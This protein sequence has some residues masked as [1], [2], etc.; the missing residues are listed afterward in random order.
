M[1]AFQYEA[2][3]LS[4]RTRVN[5]VINADTE[6]EAREMLREQ[7][8]VPTKLVVIKGGA[9]IADGKVGPLDFIFGFFKGI[10]DKDKIAFTRNIGMMLRA[11]IPIADA[12]MYFENFVTKPRFKGIIQ[13]LR[14][15]IIGGYSFSQA[16]AKHDKLF[17]TVYVNVTKAGEASGELDTSMARLAEL[18]IKAQKLKSKVIAAATYPAIVVGILC[19]VLL[20]M[21]IIVLPTFTEIY[22]S[23]GVTLPLITVV[24]IGMSNFLRDGWFIS[25]P[26]LGGAIWGAIN[27]FKSETG[28]LFLDNTLI[29]VPVLGEVIRFMNNANF[30]STLSV[31]FSSG[32][33]ITEALTL[34]AQTVKHHQIRS[35][36][37][38]A[39]YKIQA[40]QGLASALGDTKWVPDLVL[41]MLA[42]GEESGD[43]ENMLRNALEYLED[44]VNHRMEI[45]MALM[46]PCLLLVLG[47]VVAL[48]ALGIY[49]PLFGVYEHL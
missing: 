14:K 48:V 19:L 16:L 35:A 13:Q 38:Q 22:K 25:F 29:K 1:G 24:M 41:I 5:G 12:L 40:G 39:N 32:L 44:E 45:L 43:L 49:L 7:E 28:Q 36:F 21:F 15:D 23:M 47:V 11:G 20:V 3:R 30:I 9:S 17:D 27:F 10:G 31:A 8:L 6:R 2:M 42:T 34:A 37:M 33:P 26:M 18:L 4:D 46:E